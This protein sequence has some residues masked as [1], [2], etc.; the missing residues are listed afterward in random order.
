MTVEIVHIAL[1]RQICEINNI[2]FSTSHYQRKNKIKRATRNEKSVNSLGTFLRECRDCF[3]CFWVENGENLRYVDYGLSAKDVMDL[4]LVGT[5]LRNELI[6]ESVN[7]STYSIK[8]SHMTR[9]SNF[10]EYCI[11]CYNCE[12]C[13]GCVG[14]RNKKYCIFN[15]QYT[16]EEY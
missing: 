1:A 7:I 8:F 15:K 3:M 11:N 13:F 12:N 6:Y 5:S 4:T 14:L 9:N 10:L 2:I 16:E